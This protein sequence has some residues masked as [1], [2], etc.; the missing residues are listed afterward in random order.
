MLH[1]GIRRSLSLGQLGKPK[2]ENLD[3]AIGGDKQILRLEIAMNDT[4]PMR[5]RQAGGDLTWRN[6]IAAKRQ[7]PPP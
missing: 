5:C 4:F 1:G 6:P 7:R 2:V 3:V